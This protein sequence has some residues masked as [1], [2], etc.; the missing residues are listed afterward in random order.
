M[1]VRREGKGGD[2]SEREIVSSRTFAAPPER[3]F[4]AFRDPSRLARWWGPQGFSS[5]FEVFDLRPGGTWRFVMHGP[6]GVDHPNESVFLAVE[7]PR[8]IV[9]RH[10]SVGHP[11]EMTI[12][13]DEQ[14]GG[15]TRVTWRMWHETAEH[16][17]RVKPIVVP[18]NEQNFDR[19]A[20]EL[21]RTT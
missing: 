5:T 16:C 4:E 20:A 1:S 11:F 9:F 12:T 14:S 15:A 21:E 13:L 19:L 18:A 17:A 3:V 2:A 6:D 8:R 10:L 7:E